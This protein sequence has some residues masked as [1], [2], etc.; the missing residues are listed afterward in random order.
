M[1][2]VPF[3]ADYPNKALIASPE[4]FFQD[5]SKEYINFC[6]SGF[7][8]KCETPAIY[9]YEISA[10]GHIYT[11]IVTGNDV[12]DYEKGKIIGHENTIAAKEQAMLQLTLLRRAMIKPVLLGYDQHEKIDAF[13]AQYKVHHPVFFEIHLPEAGE[14]H[15][16]WQIYRNE[17]IQQLRNLF[18]HYVPEAYIA[19]GHHRT[20]TAVR[21]LRDQ[22]LSDSEDRIS[23]LAAYFPFR[24]LQIFEFNRVVDVLSKTSAAVFIARLSAFLKIRP[25]KSAKK[26]LKKHSFTMY[27]GKEWF[28]LEWKKTILSKYDKEQDILDTELFNTYV[29]GNVLKISD[30]RTTGDIIYLEGLSGTEGIQSI[31]N[32]NEH[33]AGFC[34]FPLTI[35]EMKTASN[36]GK[37]LPPKSTW[38]E[39]R[40]KNGLLIKTF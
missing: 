12:S 26:P 13:T 9:I 30:V 29:L 3:K 28:S 39:P 4:S 33:Y 27:I 7:F 18:E 17:D 36:T 32:S 10:N 25:L 6:R 14:W 2:L 8:L 5:V 35:E 21:L 38:F 40:M 22:Y 19:D 20:S 24:D 1:Q 11:G 15:R 23:V 37:V 34:L 31:V 16:Y